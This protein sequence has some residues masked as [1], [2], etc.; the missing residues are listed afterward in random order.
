MYEETPQPTGQSSPGGSDIASTLLQIGGMIYNTAQQRR[1]QKK[2]IQANKDQAEY[3]YSK[4]VEMMNRMNDY[5]NPAAQMERLKAAG[6]NPN[7]VYGQGSGGAAGNQSSIPKYNA[8]TIQYSANPIDIPGMIAMYQNVQMRQAQI[9]NLK[10]QNDQI[11]TSTMATQM[12][13]G[14]TKVNT[15]QAS[16][17]LRQSLYTNPYQ[18]AIIANHARGSNAELEQKW[19]QLSLM[20]QQQQTNYLNQEYLKKNITGAGI[21]NEQREADLLYAKYRNQWMKAGITT[22]DNPLLRIFVRMMNETGLGET[23]AFVGQGWND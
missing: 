12:S 7:M 19:K 9:N 16:E 3:A 8:P 18:A 1:M 20:D 14:L 21:Q 5:N 17:N 11:R 10:A 4:E 15:D 2:T 23:A 22:S 13:A 6:L